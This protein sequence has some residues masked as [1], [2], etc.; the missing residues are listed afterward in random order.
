MHDTPEGVNS[1]SYVVVIVKKRMISQ[2]FVTP[3][4]VRLT[5]TEEV[6]FAWNHRKKSWVE[7]GSKYLALV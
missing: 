1:K 7:S 6:N 5:T 3:G 2:T 4:T